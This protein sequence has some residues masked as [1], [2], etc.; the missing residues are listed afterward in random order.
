MSRERRIL[1]LGVV[2]FLVSVVLFSAGSVSGA[3]LAGLLFGLVAMLVARVLYLVEPRTRGR[4]R[5]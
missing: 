4:G 3:F 1:R 2:V 5:S